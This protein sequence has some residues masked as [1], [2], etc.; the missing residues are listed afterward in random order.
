MNALKNLI[1]I[2]LALCAVVLIEP[3]QAQ[4]LSVNA[5]LRALKLPDGFLPSLEQCS[6]YHAENPIRRHDIAV[7]TIYTIDGMEN[8]LC[9]LHITG[10][11]NSSV[12]IHQNCELPADVAKTYAHALKRFIDKRYHPLH[13]ENFIERDEDYKAALKIMTDTK[14]C[15]FS[16]AEID[17]TAVIRKNLPSCLPAEQ[18]E[19]SAGMIFTRRIIGADN[20][21]CK[22][23][24]VAEKYDG[25][26]HVLL[27]NVP[28]KEEND[29]PDDFYLAYDCAFTEQQAQYYLRILE[30]EVVPEDDDFDYAPVWHISPDEEVRFLSDVCEVKFRK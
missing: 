16:R 18:K 25:V 1:N 10:V 13:D 20:N 4:I 11:T 14:Y 15:R 17:N 19:T 9:A 21:L 22:V 7:N 29:Y 26:D 5:Y 24:F 8:G 2:A 28:P 12:E 3:A 23:S 6:P 27:K 30:S